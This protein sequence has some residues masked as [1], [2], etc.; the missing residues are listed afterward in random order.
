MKNDVT[1]IDVYYHLGEVYEEQ[2]KFDAAA[3]AFKR[4]REH[5][6]L[7]KQGKINADMMAYVTIENIGEEKELNS[8]RHL[9]FCLAN[10]EGS[11]VFGEWKKE[12]RRYSFKNSLGI[13]KNIV[14][15]SM[16]YSPLAD[17]YDVIRDENN[18][19]K[20]EAFECFLEDLYYSLK[21]PGEFVKALSESQSDGD[22]IRM[23]KLLAMSDSSQIKAGINSFITDFKWRSGFSEI[24]Y[25]C[26]KHSIDNRSI[27]ELLN[28]ELM[29]EQIS[30]IYKAHNDLPE[31]IVNNLKVGDY[32][33]NIAY[34]FWL[35]SL[36][37]AAVFS[38]NGL[39]I[40]SVY[41]Y[42]V[43]VSALIIYVTNVY[44]SALLNDDDVKILPELHRFGYYMALAQ[45]TLD[46]GDKVGYI[47]GL[48][49][50]L[51]ACEFA[52][53]IISSLLDDFMRG[54]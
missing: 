51:V 42:K 34:V 32:Y 11:D 41:F 16:K 25:L 40:Y 9:M 31:L 38:G 30:Y 15:V 5:Q 18:T 53:D 52:K 21:Y 2:H 29:R 1:L 26:I 4:C 37:E 49:T 23:I 36:L 10:I 12:Y 45:N 39:G 3:D 14:L 35:S 48:K 27:L 33:E 8:F 6:E 28:Y 19:D 44:N 17:I 20:A 47:R 54:I 7:Y 13:L 43:F 24:Q 46:G 50:A 22:Y